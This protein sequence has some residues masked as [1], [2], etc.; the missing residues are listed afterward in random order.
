MNWGRMAARIATSESRSQR[1]LTA[2]ENLWLAVLV[3]AVLDAHG[4]LGLGG[5]E[6]KASG[7]VFQSNAIAWLQAKRH[8]YIGSCGWICD[9][10]GI[11][12]DLPLRLALR[13]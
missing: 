2:E 10:L 3:R 12:D 11:D 8:D 13:T 4:R 5:T 9:A 1:Q 7:N 6:K